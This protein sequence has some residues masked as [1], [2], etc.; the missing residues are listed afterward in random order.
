[1]VDYSLLNQG[2]KGD[3][4]NSLGGG[5]G[6]PGPPGLPGPPGPKVCL[7]PPKE[8]VFPFCM[9]MYLAQGI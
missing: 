9:R 8:S 6:E 5:K 7:F 2:E 4:G 3:A 1:M